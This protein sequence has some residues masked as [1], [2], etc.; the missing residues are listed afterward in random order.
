MSNELLRLAW[1]VTTIPLGRKAVLLAL[2]DMA[3]KDGVCWPSRDTL[4]QMALCS[5]SSVSRHLAALIAD[6]FVEQTR[7]RQKSATYRVV[8][9]RLK[10][11]QDLSN[12]DI[13]KED[14]SNQDVSPPTSRPLTSATS[15]PMYQTPK[16]PHSSKIAEDDENPDARKLCEHLAEHVAANGS[17]RPTISKRWLTAARLLLDLDDRPLDEAL[18]LVDW[19]QADAFWSTN[20]LSMAKFREKYDQLRLKAE[21][22]GALTRPAARLPRTADEAAEWLRGQWQAAAVG[23]IER[24]AGLRYEQPDI[25]IGV[26]TPA[27]QAEFFRQHRRDWITAHHQTILQALAEGHAA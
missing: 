7:R 6:G 26:D 19:C 9:E 12:Q 13:S 5:T 21:K 4:A 18:A 16:N 14:V 17:K 24:A 15:T 1:R 25:P 10:T 2:A 11:P 27:E 3:D 20:I 22:T 8:R 23:E